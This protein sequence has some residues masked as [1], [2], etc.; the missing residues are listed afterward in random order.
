MASIHATPRCPDPD[1]ASE[2]ASY[3]YIALT[4]SGVGRIELIH[5]RLYA[6]HARTASATSF[7]KEPAFPEKTHI[8]DHFPYEI[9]EATEELA[10][11]PMNKETPPA[12]CS[13]PGISQPAWTKPSPGPPRTNVSNTELDTATLMALGIT[14]PAAILVAIHRQSRRGY[15]FDRRAPPEA[16]PQQLRELHEALAALKPHA[17]LPFPNPPPTRP[18]TT[19]C[20][21]PE[22]L[23][24]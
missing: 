3:A 6:L 2:A 12:L 9:A 21:F 14:A 8:E 5:D 18:I 7:L 16:A 4:T 13:A 15:P 20:Q 24:N 10:G 1:A 19:T 11:S 23:G 22:V 17:T